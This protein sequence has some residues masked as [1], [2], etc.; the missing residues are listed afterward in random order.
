M[1]PVATRAF[2]HTRKLVSLSSHSIS[3]RTKCVSVRV[4]AK[5]NELLHVTAR[6][7]CWWQHTLR[8]DV[9]LTAL[10]FR[11]PETTGH[12]PTKAAYPTKKPMQ[13]HV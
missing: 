8:V 9:A 13:Y 12:H 5:A 10:E 7:R 4:G 6:G 1:S 3:P 2:K 11:K